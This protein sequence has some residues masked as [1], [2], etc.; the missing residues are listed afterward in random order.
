[1]PDLHTQSQNGLNE[2]KKPVYF[3]R[4]HRGIKKASQNERLVFQFNME[5][6]SEALTKFADAYFT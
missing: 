6:I 3:Y 4:L 1:M 2:V 5:N